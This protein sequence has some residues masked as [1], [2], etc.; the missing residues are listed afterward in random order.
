MISE[1][2]RPTLKDLYKHA[3]PHYAAYWEDIGIYLD[4]EPGCL[5]II[6]K[7]NPG[8]ASGCCKDLWKKWLEVD[9]NATWEKLFTAIDDVVIST[10]GIHIRTY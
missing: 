3:T 6:Q 8:D 7:D 10:S 1:T 2:D 9:L 5:K 4:I